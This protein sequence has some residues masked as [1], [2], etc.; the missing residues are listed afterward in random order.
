MKTIATI[1]LATLFAI[2]AVSTAQSISTF[3]I[4]GL[5]NQDIG[6]LISLNGEQAVR[7]YL[8]QLL[9][10]LTELRNNSFYN[11]G[12]DDNDDDVE[13]ET[14]SARD[15]ERNEAELRGEVDMNDFRNGIVFFVYGEDE[16]DVDDVDREDSYNDVDE[17]GDDLQKVRVDSDLDDKEDYE[18][19]VRN[20]DAN[21]RHYF[22]ICVEYEDEDDD[23]RLECGSVEDFET[24]NRNGSNNNDDEPDVT[25]H[26]ARDIRDDEA[27]LRGEVDMN[28]FRDGIVFFV[29]GEDENDV[30][31]ATREDSYNDVDEQ[32]DDLQ[33]VR[34]DSDL[35]GEEDY[36]RTVTNLDDDTRYYYAMC[37]EYEDED[38]DE[39][40]ECGSVEEFRTDN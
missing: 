6:Q 8:V 36:E 16:D 21:T 37:V 26:S 15:I 31:E 4:E 7:D 35:D 25:T 40:L 12:G 13:A 33:K 17:R 2:P 5:L 11:N 28:D 1:I 27:E 34:V 3:E 29:Y 22:R 30:E 14:F 20:L 32:G 18:R 39:T 24:D 38:D 19:T 9:F 10:I 23:E